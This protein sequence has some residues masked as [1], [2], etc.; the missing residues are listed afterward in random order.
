MTL[1]DQMTIMTIRFGVQKK[2]LSGASAYSKNVA[3]RIERGPGE[4]LVILT[5]KPPARKAM[6]DPRKLVISPIDALN[7]LI[8]TLF[9]G[10][11]RPLTAGQGGTLL[12]AIINP[13]AALL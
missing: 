13:H 11:T 6:R 9:Q 4:V 3:K 10:G 7:R 12:I 5:L 8:F 1:F 2:E